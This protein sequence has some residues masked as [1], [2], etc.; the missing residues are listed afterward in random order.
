VSL[1]VY[2]PG[3]AETYIQGKG[4]LYKRSGDELNLQTC[5]LCNKGGFHFF[6][7]DV[8]GAWSCK[9]G[10]C[11][12]V[13]NFYQLLKEFGDYAD[14]TRPGELVKPLAQTAPKVKKAHTIADMQS[15]KLALEA[16]DDAKAYLTGRGLTSATWQAWHLG[17]KT[18]RD[19]VK[20]LLIPYIKGDL[21][22]DVKYRSLPPTAKRFQRLQ[23]GESILYGHHLLKEHWKDAEKKLY[24]VEGELDAMTMWQQGFSPVLSTTT[25]AAGFKTEWYDMIAAYDPATIVICYDADI[26]GQAGADKHLKKFSELDRLCVN[27]ILP[28]AKDA[29]EYF[30]THTAADF[31]AL[32]A[33]TAVPEVDGCYSIASVMDRLEEQLWLSANAFDG[34]VSQFTD[35]NAL[36]SGGYWNGQLI[37]VSAPSGTGK[38]LSI[39]T[40]IPTTHG[41]VRM[42]DISV[43]DIVLDET[44]LPCNVTYVSP[45]QYRDTYDI[46]FSD[47][48]IVT[49]CSDH[50][51]L[52]ETAQERDTKQPGSLRTTKQLADSVRCWG[53]SRNNH[54][55]RLSGAWELPIQELPIDPYVF[56]A[57]LG[58]GT[59]GNSGFTSADIDVVEQIRSAGFTVDK[60]P[61]NDPTRPYA[62]S[63]KGLAAVLA[64][65]GSVTVSVKHD[66]D[67]GQCAE[68]GK[69]RWLAGRQLCWACHGDMSIRHRHPRR[70]FGRKTW[71]SGGV[72]H[73]KWV[74]SEYLFASKAQRL[75]LLQGLMDTDGSCDK[76]GTCE[77][78]N[79][80]KD[81]ADAVYHL[82]V[83]LGVKAWRRTK[84]ATLYGK[85][86]KSAYLVGFT[87]TVPVFRLARKLARLPTTLRVTSNYRYITAVTPRPQ[88]ALKCI[89]VD[90]P[91]KLYLCGRAGVPT[92]NTS[93]VLQELMWQA[94]QG[95]PTFLLCLEMPETM[96]LLKIIEK[97]Y[98][99]PIPKIRLEHVQ[100]FRQ[101][102]A[103]IPFFM[104]SKGG[105]LDEAE[106]VIRTAVKRHDLKC[107]AFDN[108]NYFVRSMDHVQQEIALVTRRLK[109]I[110]IDLH[111]PIILIAQP[112][113]FDEN[114]RMMGSDDL[115]DS[116]AIRQ[117]S[118]SI[119]LLHRRSVNPDIKSFGSA[120]IGTQSPYT[121]VRV[122]KAR[123]GPGG[124]CYLYFEGARSTFRELTPGES[125]SMTNKND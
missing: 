41:F 57:W 98:G 105:T 110:A 124:D 88:T 27:V 91:S 4:W 117:D 92:H 108:L 7:N 43:G 111:I 69:D 44:G 46:R 62:W 102:L 61:V 81:I 104:G 89:S 100:E 115:K 109:E 1:P 85:E 32:V 48:T 38:A 20:W 2:Q 118:D 119:I 73:K 17:V 93:F 63:V 99:I 19:G 34:Q 50:Q 96:M 112:R 70:L 120:I 107:V 121:C 106:K 21:V 3:Q 64:G 76:R 52:T 68:C 83:S 71:F 18:D 116:S 47:G 75:A 87:T 94:R 82:V 14:S 33:N 35:V 39:D 55:V 26:A 60:C 36:I 113:K 40:D 74:P 53:G 114:V 25:G 65:V 90:S 66:A 103:K 45:T 9:A 12:R 16:D 123:Y 101:E 72:L 86:C 78:S 30:T 31:A 58:D 10:S 80:N 37:T 122:S 22:V 84:R 23:G 95:S 8:K 13:G 28:D 56:G 125:S 49:A 42:G 15:F 79:T 51:W 11:G 77:F 29:N 6:I 97:E 67:R 5:P 54:G 24:M 59:R